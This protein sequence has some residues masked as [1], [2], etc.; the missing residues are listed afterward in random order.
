MKA[1]L[2]GNISKPVVT[3]IGVWDPLL[4]DHRLLFEQIRARASA[5]GLASLIVALAPDPITF[6][7]GRAKVPIYNDA[8]TRV[9]LI[10]TCGVDGVLQVKFTDA[11][12]G[13]NAADLFA[14]LHAHVQIRELWLGARQTFGRGVEGS[15]SAIAEL[16]ERHGITLVRTAPVRLA[17]SVVRE[18]LLEGRFAEAVRLVGRPPVLQKPQKGKMRL[19]WHPGRYKVHVLED[20]CLSLAAG[21]MEHTEVDL[22]EIMLIGGKSGLSTLVWPSPDARYLAFHHGPAD[23][24][25]AS[26]RGIAQESRVI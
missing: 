8:A 20:P 18:H 2:Y 26:T 14:L 7:A 10:Q 17:T 11:D 1:S 15:M 3:A 21:S 12:I 24:E 25:M 4:P 23:K 5:A 22:F 13:G 9:Q 6:L 19:A 16:A